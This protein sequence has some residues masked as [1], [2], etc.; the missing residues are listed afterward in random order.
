M[1]ESFSKPWLQIRKPED[2]EEVALG[3]FQRQVNQVKIYNQ[4][5][6]H[7][8]VIPG[9]VKNVHQIPF[10]PISFFKTHRVFGEGLESHFSFT[11]SSTSGQGQSHHHIADLS[12]YHQVAADSFQFAFSNPT[13]W[14]W[15]ALLP[16]YL[17]RS[18]SSLVEMIR[19]FMEGRE[20]HFYLYDHELL[21]HRLQESLRSKKK[22]ILIGVSYAL[23]D[24]AE[25]YPSLYDNLVVIETGGMK[26]RRAEMTKEELHT[27]IRER[28]RGVKLSSE[29]GMTELMSQAYAKDGLH[30]DCPPWMRVVL[31]EVNDP[32]SFV[33]RPNKTGVVNIVDLGN[34]DSCAFIATDD[35]GRLNEKGQFE[36]LGRLDHAELRGC[37]LMVL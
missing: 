6:K 13:E 34:R 5:C 35:L 32:F 4:Y 3:V 20:D 15:H 1:D 22:V 30:F 23:I 14:E 33:T 17:E 16:S 2:F 7:I 19:Y 12:L 25:A 29:Y 27:F 8:G 11:S 37:N 36:I 18:G 28:M 10:L 9:E 24:F 31:R 21:F 26:G